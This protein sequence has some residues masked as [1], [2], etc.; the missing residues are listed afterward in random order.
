MLEWISQEIFPNFIHM[1]E[2]V[3]EVLKKTL[4]SH[5]KG[6]K[7]AITYDL[8]EYPEDISVKTYRGSFRPDLQGG[9]DFVNYIIEN[10]VSGAVQC[11]LRPNS[12][13]RK[14]VKELQDY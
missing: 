8:P 4:E 10:Q 5:F 13:S 1:N 2:N 3:I 12:L 14:Q 7:F 11:I 9:K 6:F